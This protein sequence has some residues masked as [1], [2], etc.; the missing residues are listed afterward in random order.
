MG[1]PNNLHLF[2][3]FQQNRE[4]FLF[5]Q[6]PMSF[7]LAYDLTSGEEVMLRIQGPIM[8]KKRFFL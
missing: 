5:L 6:H 7:F 2:L 3:K 4:E 1:Y 8:E